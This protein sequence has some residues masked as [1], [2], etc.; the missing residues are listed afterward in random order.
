MENKNTKQKINATKSW[1]FEKFNK[2]DKPLAKLTKEKR[3]KAQTNKIR[4]KREITMTL[5]IHK[6]LYKNTLKDYMSPNSIT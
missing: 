6:G 4:N 2:I 5:Q 1:F 3:K